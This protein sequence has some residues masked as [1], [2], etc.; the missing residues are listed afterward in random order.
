MMNN[1]P[2]FPLKE[3]LQKAKLFVASHGLVNHMTAY[4]K[5]ALGYEL[6]NDETC[7][8]FDYALDPNKSLYSSDNF[9]C[10][11]NI[12]YWSPRGPIERDGGVYSDYHLKITIRMNSFELTL[13]KINSRENMIS[14]IS[15]LAG[16]IEST[17]PKTITI[18][19]TTHEELCEKRQIAHEQFVASRL[20]EVIGKELVRNL[21]VG[22]N[23][24]ILRIP[25]KF[26]EIYG[27]MPDLGLYHYDQIRYRN[28]RG[29]IKA[30]AGFILTVNK[31]SDD[32]YFIV[33]KRTS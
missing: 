26:V 14:S 30:R 23:P 33:A 1:T 29:Q 22:G 27:K 20:Y 21:R 11:L 15:M 7:L 4:S 9:C 18:T 8:S 17:I 10:T 13:E 2:S 28:R 25:D 24:K 3:A 6:S 32:S 31:N 19:V 5:S 12:C 16:M